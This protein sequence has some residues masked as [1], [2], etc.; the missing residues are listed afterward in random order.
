[1]PVADASR[2]ETISA[3]YSCFSSINFL[4]AFKQALFKESGEREKPAP[5][6]RNFHR[7]SIIS[8][9][10]IENRVIYFIATNCTWLTVFI[11]I[12]PRHRGFFETVWS[13]PWFITIFQCFFSLVRC[14]ERS[15]QR[16][17]KREFF[18]H[19]LFV[20]NSFSHFA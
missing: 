5:H 15:I 9:L 2:Y 1:M 16:E 10:R 12:P 3:C 4:I 13:K 8:S 7:F 14:V 18:S 11:L 20:W 6:S 19:K 17:R